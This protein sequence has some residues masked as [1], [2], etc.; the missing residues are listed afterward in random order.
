MKH[1]GILA[2]SPDGAALAFKEFCHVGYKK[3]GEAIHPDITLDYIAMGRSLPAWDRND[4]SEVRST[5]ANSIDR[6]AAVGAEFFFC[7]DN[8]AHIALE[9]EGPALSLPGLNIADIVAHE[10][11]RRGM[12]KVG[13]LGTRFTML[14][15]V[16]PR[17]LGVL[18]IESVSPND[19]DRGVI[20]EIIFSEL[21]NGIIRGESRDQYC[22]IIDRLKDDGCD[23]VALV[24]TE[25]PLL[26]SE[27]DSSL[28]ILDSTRLIAKAAFE[29]GVE[30]SP[31]PSWFGGPVG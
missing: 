21:C 27:L 10:A 19:A 28:P 17:A 29:I 18:G 22:E 23:G 3:F 11:K 5:L 8:T 16:Y 20:D 31:I 9:F 7:P 4:L 25:I 14:G 15:H 12:T 26:I 1:V 24:C 13:V 6:L 30:E 2:H